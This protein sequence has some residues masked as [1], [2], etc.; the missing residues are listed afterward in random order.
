[1]KQS[2]PQTLQHLSTQPPFPTTHTHRAI[3]SGASFI[4]ESFLFFVAASLI[5]AETWRSSLKES[6]RREG[7]AEGMEELRKGVE[8]LT[9]RVGDVERALRGKV[10]VRD[11]TEESPEIDQ[12]EDEG[13]ERRVL[14]VEQR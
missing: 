1:M 6:K 7:V 9:M 4:A 8:V 12:V 5:F 2:K 13:L 10:R 14:E 3:E 11:D